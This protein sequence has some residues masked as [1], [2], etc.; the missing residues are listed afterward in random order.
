MS[1]QQAQTTQWAFVVVEPGLTAMMFKTNASF[2]PDN[3]FS[4]TTSFVLEMKKHT[5]QNKQRDLWRIWWS[6]I[7]SAIHQGAQL[8]FQ[9]EAPFSFGEYGL[10]AHFLKSKKC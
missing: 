7:N 8:S 3:S 4:W 1:Q 2:P 10:E 5:F 9:H 6:F